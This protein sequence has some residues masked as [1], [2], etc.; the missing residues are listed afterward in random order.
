MLREKNIKAG[1]IRPITLWPFPSGVISGYAAQD[2]K[3]FVLEM[4]SGQMVEDVRLA[5][6]DDKRVGF[7]GRM[8]GAV[9]DEEEA[10]GEVEKFL[11]KKGGK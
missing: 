7:F 10:I 4:S 2:K 9:V 11:G 3:F 6:Q 1:L 5:V 8:G